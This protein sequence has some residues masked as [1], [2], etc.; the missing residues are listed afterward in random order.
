MW[1]QR[2]TA[3]CH[4]SQMTTNREILHEV[5]NQEEDRILAGDSSAWTLMLIKQWRKRK[6]FCRTVPLCYSWVVGSLSKLS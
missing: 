4:Y 5:K 3:Q 2:M 1:G 6:S